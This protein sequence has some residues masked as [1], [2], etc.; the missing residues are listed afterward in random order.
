MTDMS[1][2][3]V[4]SLGFR[5]D[6]MLRRMAGSIIVEHAAHLVVR[7]PANP[8]FWWGNFVLFDGPPGQDD[9]RRWLAVFAEAFSRVGT[10]RLRSGPHRRRRGLASAVIGHAGRWARRELDA[11]TLVIV[12]DPDDDAIRIYR[13]L[14]FT[15]TERQ[16]QLYREPE[17]HSAGTD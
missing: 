11:H 7:T 1:T 17:S 10:R 3:R 9:G 16:I 4:V 5:T 2:E 13:A 6:L 14:G 15:E 12:A 8:R